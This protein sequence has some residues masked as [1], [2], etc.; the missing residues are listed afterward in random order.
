[1]TFVDVKEG[2]GEFMRCLKAINGRLG[3]HCEDDHFQRERHVGPLLAQRLRTVA[4]LLEHS[5]K[6]IR[7]GFVE[8][9]MAHD[10]GI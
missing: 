3:N 5:L 9:R 10:E 6:G 8:G 1:M 7:G 4:T 2:L